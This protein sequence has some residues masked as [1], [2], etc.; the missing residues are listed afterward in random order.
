MVFRMEAA[1]PGLQIIRHK[2]AAIFLYLFTDLSELFHDFFLSTSCFGRISKIPVELFC[3]CRKDR[4]TFLTIVTDGNNKIEINIG[5]FIDIVGCVGGDVNS[6]F[7]HGR[8]GIRIYTVG[9]D[10]CAINISLPIRKIS[11]IAFSD[12][13]S[14]A[15]TGT[16]H[17]DFILFHKIIK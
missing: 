8:N 14:A 15:V 7:F 5:I 9:F 1:L 17:Q 6:I 11:Q 12:L 13:T 2:L 3:F 4:T 16:K 10:P